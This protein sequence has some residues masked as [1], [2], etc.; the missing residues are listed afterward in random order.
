MQQSGR[1]GRNVLN[2]G[3]DFDHTAK[4]TPDQF[5][6]GGGLDVLLR[7]MGAGTGAGVGGGQQASGGSYDLRSLVDSVQRNIDAANQANDSRY[8]QELGLWDQGKNDQLAQIK[9]IMGQILGAGTSPDPALKR[10][11]IRAAS[12]G[13]NA[14]NDLVSRGLGNTNLLADVDRG[15]AD[16]SAT[17]TE[18]IYN[19]TNAQQNA[20]RSQQ[21]NLILST[22]SGYTQGKAGAIR[23]RSDVGPDLGQIAQ[24]LAQAGSQGAGANNPALNSI[25]PLLGRPSSRRGGGPG[26][27]VGSWNYSNGSGADGVPSQGANPAVVPQGTIAQR[28]PRQQ[29]VGDWSDTVPY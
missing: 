7:G 28:K 22:L 12:V 18:D 3:G 27:M 29:R 26:P 6:P 24:L 19:T 8:N 9:Q 14:H 21:L 1:A 11:K 10:E 13:A 16:D 23:S 5:F 4:A 15:V 25:M 20:A 2:L 17:R